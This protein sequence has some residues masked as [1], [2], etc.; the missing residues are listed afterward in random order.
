M[1]HVTQLSWFAG[2]AERVYGETVEPKPGPNDTTLFSC[3]W[4]Q[5]FGVV[6]AIVPW[7]VPIT[8]FAGQVGAAVAC[9]NTIVYKDSEKSPLVGA[10][11]AK[12]CS[13]AGFPPGVIN[14][15]H[16]HGQPTGEALTQ[17]EDVRMIHFTGSCATG[18]RIA[19]EAARS[20]L[21]KVCLELGGKS[22]AIVFD[23][24]DLSKAVKSAYASFTSNSGQVCVSHSRVYVQEAIYDQFVR[25]LKQLITKAKIGDPMQPETELGPLVDAKQYERVKMY[26]QIAEEETNILHGASEEY[27]KKFEKG[28]YVSPTI[29]APRCNDARVLREEIFGPVACVMPFKTEEEVLA[30]V[31]DTEY[32][33][34]GGIY[35]K[36]LSR[37]LRVS[38]LMEAGTVG[39]NTGILFDQRLPFGGEHQ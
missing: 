15:L 17:A 34:Q 22:A 7:N 4:R 14:V 31:N 27:R 13:E 9:G 12:L 1:S 20:N 19:A 8:S 37:A 28:Y 29:V 23:D 21:K 25:D 24:A 18:K 26:L 32:G 10:Y 39:I 30:R 3:S 11:L 38:R 5:P 33:L 36:D 2:I 35:T 16:G 6:A